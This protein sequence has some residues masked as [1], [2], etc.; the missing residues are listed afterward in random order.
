VPSPSLVSALGKFFSESTYPML[1]TGAGVSNKAGLPTWKKLV[2]DMAEAIRS[3]DPLTSTLMLETATSGDYTLAVDYFKLTKKVLAGDKNKILTK[4]LDTYDFEPIVPLATLPFR[5]CI[6]TNFDRSIFDAIASSR[7]RAARDYKYGDNSFKQAQW[8]DGLHVARIHGAIESPADMV[9]SESQFQAL[10]ADADYEDYLRTCFVRRNVLFVGFS[11]YDPAIR[12]IFQQ[13]DQRFGPATPGRHMAL[14]PANAQSDFLQKA[15]RLNIEVVQYDPASD[16]ADLWTAISAFST[17]STKSPAIQSAAHPYGFTKRY[18]AACYARAK[19]QEVTGPLR[20]AVAEG[21]VSALLQEAVPHAVSERDLV[22]KLRLTLGTR[23]RETQRCLVASLRSLTEA[24]LCRRSKAESGRGSNYAWIGGAQHDRSLETAI[25]TLSE[26]VSKRAYLQ[27]GWKPGREAADTL[28]NFFDLLIRKRGWDLGAAFASG[29]PP[30]NASVESLFGESAIGLPAFDR[31]RLLRVITGMLQRPSPEESE[32]LSELGKV[33]FAVELAFQSPGSSLFHKETLPRQI[34]FDANVLLPAITEGHPFR[35]VYLDAIKRLKEA[36]ASAAFKLHLKVSTAYLNE[37]IS[38]RRNAED[39]ANKSGS[40][41]PAIARSDAM[42]HGASNV[43]VFVGAYATWIDLNGEIPFKDFLSRYAPFTSE[44]D[45]QRWLTRQG[46]E[47]VNSVKGPKYA[48]FYTILERATA[49]RLSNGK[50]P[51]LIEHDAAQLSMLDMEH[52]KQERT[53][54][55]TADRQLQNAIAGSRHSFLAELM[56]SH[57]GL[58]QFIQLLLGGIPDSGGLTAMLWS[59]VISDRSQAVR[60]YFTSRG[61]EQYDEGL[62]M[63]MP[64]II[65]SYAENAAKELDRSGLSLD[66]DDPARR[67]DAFRMLGSLE[68]DYISKMHASIVA[69][70][71]G[72]TTR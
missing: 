44:S 25:A 1:F 53:L 26:S 57:V 48:D 37:I 62:A 59:S 16:H 64:K 51:I 7:Q 14:L 24:G 20:E 10:L 32:L 47:V 11:F 49:D 9:L 56:V 30:E 70:R 13:I 60:S 41:F 2:E 29:R 46:F 36:A 31:E 15:N 43:N 63:A 18:L 42:Y 28:A 17:G 39:F 12:H 67:A 52:V 33:S 55:V 45:L 54:F 34:F 58:I 71:S 27:E 19:T 4:L 61:L 22:E 23:G 38:H 65:E 66:S 21:I 5:A 3:A 72:T 69:R 68:R 35:Q 40:D 50:Q 8:D 6:T